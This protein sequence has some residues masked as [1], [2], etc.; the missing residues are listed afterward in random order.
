M[1]L[2]WVAKIYLLMILHTETGSKHLMYNWYFLFVVLE[3]ANIVLFQ[4]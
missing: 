2:L 4:D 3:Q 1:I